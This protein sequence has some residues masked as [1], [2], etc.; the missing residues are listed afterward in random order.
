MD[1]VYLLAILSSWAT[2]FY[3]SKT[4]QPLRLRGDRWQYRLFTQFMEQVPIPEAS[5]P[6]RRAIAGLAEQAGTIGRQRY[7]VQTN[8]QHRLRQTFGEAASG[9]P[10]GVLNEKAQEWWE[11]TTN[12]LGAALK[13]SFKLAS[14]PM[15]N[16]RT[17]DEWEPYL[18][19][20]RTDVDRLS[21]TLADVESEINQRVYWLFNLTLDDITLLQKEVE[22]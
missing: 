12:Q 11:L 13:T 2:W 1:D 5:E 18:V 9:E 7:E 15:S 4:A 20:K 19:E 22:H 8:V 14:N 16:T 6:D 21:R 17:A 3:I 10:L